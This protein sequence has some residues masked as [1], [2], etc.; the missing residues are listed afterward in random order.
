MEEWSR[1]PLRDGVTQDIKTWW[2]AKAENYITHRP[3]AEV[4]AQSQSPPQAQLNSISMAYSP[5]ATANIAGNAAQASPAALA[6][7]TAGSTGPPPNY[8]GNLHYGNEI[9]K[10]SP[11]P[12][13]VASRDVAQ[14]NRSEVST[15]YR[16]MLRDSDDSDLQMLNARDVDKASILASTQS[17]L[18]F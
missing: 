8:Q 13:T 7:E 10:H 9:L 17:N 14:H 5:A 11:P 12:E 16:S 2:Q 4:W 18:Y 1:L 6:V 15:G 3:S